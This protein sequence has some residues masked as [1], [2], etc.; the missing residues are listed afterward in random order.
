MLPAEFGR[1]IVHVPAAEAVVTVTVPDVVP[2]RLIAPVVPP[3]V[4]TVIVLA[5]VGA[6]PNTKAPLPVSSEITPASS[7]DVVAANADSLLLVN[8]SV[9]EASGKV[10]VRVVPVVIPDA[11]NAASLVASPSS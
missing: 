6:V 2:L 3:A 7:E 10:K 1:V 4:P 9:P 11:W 5:K 8:A